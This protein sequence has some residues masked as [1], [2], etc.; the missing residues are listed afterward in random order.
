MES[1]AETSPVE[2][3]LGEEVVR[4]EG[5]GKIY[6]DHRV[7]TDVNVSVRLGQTL[8]IMGGSGAGKTTLLRV[9]MGQDRPEEGRVLLFGNDLYSLDRE[10][11]ESVRRRFGVV[12]QSGALLNSLTVAQNVAL[13]LFELTKLTKREIREVVG[14]K[15]SEVGLSRAGKLLPSQISGGMR[16]R[17]GIAR[18]LVHDP[19]LIYYDEPTSGLDPIMT[20]V[21]TQ[22]IR[23]IRDKRKVASIV[24][25]H[26]MNSAFAVGDRMIMLLEGR[27]VADGSPDDIR[28]TEDPRVIQFVRGEADG[29]ISFGLAPA[30]RVK[31]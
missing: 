15:L 27:V 6:G 25:T 4:A 2:S 3:D 24:V 26:D 31:P 28:E 12:F 16:K 19:E 10:G 20:A 5:V 7:L 1:S 11:L 30:R 17:V 21:M 13:P 14:R 29:P 9:L 23:N 18:A 22:K 8:V